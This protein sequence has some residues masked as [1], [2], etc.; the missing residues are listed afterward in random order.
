MNI[1][2]FT[3][4]HKEHS[5]YEKNTI[6][7][8][9]GTEYVKAAIFRVEDG[10]VHIKGYAKAKQQSDA[11]KGAM[12]VDLQNVIE[13]CDM[14][15]GE[16]LYGIEKE[17]LPTH[18]VMGIAG[19]LV[20]GITIMAEYERPNPEKKIDQKEIDDAIAS[21]RKNSFPE[22]KTQIAEDM[23][24]KQMNIEE[25]DSVISDTFIDGYRVNNPIGFV[26]K[27]V[28]FRVFSTFSPSIHLSSLKS[29]VKTLDLEI[30]SIIVE[31]Y[32][33]ARSYRGS[34]ADNFSAIFV[35]IGGGTTDLALVENGGVVGTKMFAVGGRVFTKRIE[36]T[37]GVGYE[38]AENKKIEYSLDTLDKLEKIKI[39]KVMTKDARTLVRGIALSLEDFEEI[40]NFPSSILM[41]GGGS[42]LP[43]IKAEVLNYPWLQELPF[44]KFPKFEFIHPEMIADVI[45]DTKK[46]KDVTDVAV[47]CLARMALEKK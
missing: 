13:N 2:F 1:P 16:A 10:Q 4:K 35:D 27:S 26:G 31:P 12:I 8:D 25:I 19:E 5:L 15:I 33:I 34:K 41:C 47:I 17:E 3:K 21:V 29:I 24:L 28:N 44:E 22:A 32:A 18:V 45:D 20:Y 23:G 9:V 11:M 39:A 37:L 30:A 38:I 6:A 14:A 7:L 36:Q 40:E 43:E 46:I 42:L